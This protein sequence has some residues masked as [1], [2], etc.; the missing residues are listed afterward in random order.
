MT[1]S[2]KNEIFRLLREDEEF[3][4]ALAGLIGIEDLRKGFEDLKNAVA[5]LVATQKRTELILQQLGE[6]LTRLEETVQRLAETQQKTEERLTRLEETVQRL[7]ETQQKTEQE[8]QELVRQFRELSRQVARLS[9]TI[10][11]GLE[12]IARVVAPGWFF[13]HVGVSVDDL[14]RRFIVVDGK[15]I[16]VN[17]YGEGVKNGSKVFL[18]GEA[19]SRIYSKEVKD[20]DE[21]IGDLV[22]LLERDGVVYKFMFGYMVHPSAEAEARSRGIIL[23]ASYMR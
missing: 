23:I 4:Y 9:D 5:E 18:I 22:R 8:I 3:R 16:E 7:A 11:F 1:T 6:R 10:G 12:D 2:I 14:D 19:K 21:T 13:R 17:L 15:E 20:F